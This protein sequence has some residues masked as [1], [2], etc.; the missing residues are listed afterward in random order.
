MP[1]LYLP[2][3]AFQKNSAYDE[4]GIKVHRT[5]VGKL[6]KKNEIERLKSGS[7]PVKSSGG[8]TIRVF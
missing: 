4:Y 5:A 6:L 8:F 3:F 7:L 1:F 2:V